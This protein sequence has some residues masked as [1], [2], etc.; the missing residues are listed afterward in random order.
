MIYPVLARVRYRRLHE[1]GSNSRLIWP[2]LILNWLLGPALMF[3]LA[4]LFLADQP[5][6]R[7]GLILVGLARC[8]AMVLIWNSACLAAITRPQLSWSC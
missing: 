7:T 8:I 5:A 4:W 2:S 3:A 6:F 1:V